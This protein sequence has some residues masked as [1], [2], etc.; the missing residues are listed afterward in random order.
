MVLFEHILGID[1]FPNSFGLSV[2]NQ[3]P[4]ESRTS[5]VNLT[6]LSN[7]LLILAFQYRQRP[8]ILFK[9]HFRILEAE[10]KHNSI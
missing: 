8:R 6:K 9:V 5:S 2:Y 7:H 3:S 10:H 4:L 1:I